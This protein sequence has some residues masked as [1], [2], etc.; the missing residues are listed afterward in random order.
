MRCDGVSQRTFFL[1]GLAR[2]GGSPT[3]SGVAVTPDG[4]HVFVGDTYESFA[5]VTAMERPYLLHI[6]L[7]SDIDVPRKADAFV[8]G[9]GYHR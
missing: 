9:L 6:G 4:R 5:Y 7:R 8:R 1:G 3:H 2:G